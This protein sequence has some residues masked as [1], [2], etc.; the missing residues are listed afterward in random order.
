MQE[1]NNLDLGCHFDEMWLGALMYADDLILI[2]GSIKKL[3]CLLDCCDEFGLRMNLNFKS[4][5]SFYYCTSNN[6][7]I[8]FML[9]CDLLPC[10]CT[11]FKYL[12]MN[13]GIRQVKLYVIPGM[14]ELENSY[15]CI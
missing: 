5:K 6:N 1:L 11:T 4:K 2:S 12:G 7:R 10:A 14:N 9:S 8:N 15:R 13:L 3:Q